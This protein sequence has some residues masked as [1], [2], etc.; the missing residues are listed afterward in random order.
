MA[1]IGSSMG[2]SR[3]QRINQAKFGDISV[4]YG[5]DK[6][7]NINKKVPS[8]VL[9]TNKHESRMEKKG[10][11][12]TG[13]THRP[14]ASH[15]NYRK[16]L[17]TL[18]RFIK[19]SVISTIVLFCIWVYVTNDGSQKYQRHR[20][21]ISDVIS[22]ISNKYWSTG[23]TGGQSAAAWSRQFR[24]KGA[25]SDDMSNPHNGVS[26]NESI[27]QKVLSDF[28]KLV[29]S[30]SEGYTSNKKEE[31]NKHNENNDKN[32]IVNNSNDL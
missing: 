19:L 29:K 16:Y 1:R 26:D 23:Y 10:F 25:H 18:P 17:I 32:Y 6:R 12:G 4:R 9:K 22:Q 5:K 21:S 11:S 2:N 24:S 13:V 20:R 8:S 14:R 3:T 15:E 27:I 7:S 28:A 30:E 31:N